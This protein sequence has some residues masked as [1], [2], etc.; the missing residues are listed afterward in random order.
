LNILFSRSKRINDINE[1]NLTSF[2][3]LI[4]SPH[5]RQHQSSALSKRSYAQVCQTIR[6]KT[7]LDT[8]IEKVNINANIRA[9]TYLRQIR[10]KGLFYV[11]LYELLFGKYQQLYGGGELKRWL[12][13]HIDIFLN[14]KKEVMIKRNPNNLSLSQT[15][16]VIQR[17]PRYVRVNTLH[18]NTT[19]D[20][21]LS[22]LYDE[23]DVS[24]VGANVC[25]DRYIPDLLV[26]HYSC[27]IPW[28]TC[29]LAITGKVILQ[30]KSSCLA[31]LAMCSNFWLTNNKHDFIDACAAPGNKTLH[32]AAL[33]DK[34][35]KHIGLDSS[36]Q[37]PSII[38]IFAC[39]RSSERYYLLKQRLKKVLPNDKTRKTIVN[40]IPL[41]IDFLQINTSDIK[42]QHVKSILIDPSCSGSGII[43]T[44]D[45][46]LDLDQEKGLSGTTNRIQYLSNFHLIMLKH[47][48]SFPQAERIVYSTCSIYEQENECVVKGALKESNYQLNNKQ[49]RWNIVLPTA[50]KHWKRRGYDGKSGL[51]KEQLNCLIR[52]DGLNGDETNGFFIC[53]LEREYITQQYLKNEDS[54][55]RWL[56]HLRSAIPA[57]VRVY[58]D[59]GWFN[60]KENDDDNI[61]QE[62]M[63]LCTGKTNKH[64][65]RCKKSTGLSI[66]NSESKKI[67][68]NSNKKIEKKH[69][70]KQKQKNFKIRRLEIK[71]EEKM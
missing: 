33:I 67:Y 42:Y 68:N 36:S 18:P 54:N 7:Q 35:F 14:A 66:I 34:H 64:S 69:R 1:K 15:L 27:R 51:S 40:I 55:H 2:K 25:I 71:R 29:N 46:V 70:W 8:I 5:Y 56:D 60:K 30:E 65:N 21:C 20:T 37:L 62:H 19:L 17:F 47:A 13:Y 44:P 63:H 6:Y 45:R 23:Y 22:S 24:I 9:T 38:N 12:T 57:D 11:M 50:L 59:N 41:H 52:A 49:Q 32:I 43:N 3:H 53:Y 61:A 48:M 39:D 4:Y 26:F 31:G 10:N 58:C 28:H 16:S